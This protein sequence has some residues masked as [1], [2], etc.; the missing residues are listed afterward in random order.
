LPSSSSPSAL[1]FTTAKLPYAIHSRCVIKSS[2]IPCGEMNYVCPGL[3]AAMK[4][5]K[6]GQFLRILGGKTIEL[7]D[8]I[9]CLLSPDIASTY[10][11]D[12]SDINHDLN[13]LV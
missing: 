3:F 6:S 5:G 10:Q 11:L 1:L 9:S 4:N 8:E 2:R 7:G 12:E 13:C